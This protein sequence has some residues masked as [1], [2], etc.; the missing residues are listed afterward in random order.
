MNGFTNKSRHGIAISLKPSKHEN[1]QAIYIVL[2]KE[3]LPSQ[4]SDVKSI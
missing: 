1:D 4:T 3:K 2:E